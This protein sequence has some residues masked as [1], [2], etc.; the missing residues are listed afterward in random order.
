MPLLR[1]KNLL[2]LH[3]SYLSAPMAVNF[4][5]KTVFKKKVWRLVWVRTNKR[6]T[7]YKSNLK[8]TTVQSVLQIGKKIFCHLCS[9]ELPPTASAN[10]RTKAEG[11]RA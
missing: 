8:K 5:K 2:E 11:A 4:L 3:A 1:D 10:P 9:I 7:M 6:R